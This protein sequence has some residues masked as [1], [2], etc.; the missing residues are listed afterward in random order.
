MGKMTFSIREITAHSYAISPLNQFLLSAEGFTVADI[1]I[2]DA[3]T[4]KDV[5]SSDVVFMITETKRDFQYFRM[6]N[7]F[8]AIQ[9]NGVLEKETK[10]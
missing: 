2:G 4:L 1:K 7:V 10:P 8:K 6:G 9:I 5:M 3:V